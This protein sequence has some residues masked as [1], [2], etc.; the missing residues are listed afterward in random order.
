MTHRAVDLVA[1]P[2]C[3]ARVGRPCKRFRQA[4]STGHRTHQIRIQKAGRQQK[5][6]AKK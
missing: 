5:A 3:G 1:C 4:P 6:K 2:V